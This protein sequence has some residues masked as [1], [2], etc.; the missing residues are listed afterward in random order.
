MLPAEHTASSLF[1]AVL[2]EALDRF[3]RALFAARLPEDPA[4]FKSEYGHALAR[5]EAVRVNSTRRVE[6]ARFIRSRT[7]ELVQFGAPSGAVPLTD[8]LRERPERPELEE[9]DLPG[10]PGFPLEVPFA[11]AGKFGVRI[12]EPETTRA[13]SGLLMLH[14]LLNPAAPGARTRS[15]RD[16]RT[17]ASAV[18]SQQLHGGVYA[19]PFELNGVIQAAAALGV[20]SRPSLLLGRRKRADSPRVQAS[21]VGAAT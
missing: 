1:H 5:F 3:P 14:D 9:L 20:L 4:L 6:I 21:L 10:A 17:K 7:L 19:L 2:M 13:L 15:G 18:L 12:F 11:G 16:P 8:H